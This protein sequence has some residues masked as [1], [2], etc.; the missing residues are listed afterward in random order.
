MIK[1]CYFNIYEKNI[2]V[3]YLLFMKKMNIYV[4]NVAYYNIFEEKM[5]KHVENIAYSNNYEEKA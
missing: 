5:H 2:K 3:T 1:V 4:K